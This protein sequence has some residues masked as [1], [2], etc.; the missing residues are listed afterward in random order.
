MTSSFLYVLASAFFL[1]LAYSEDFEI[2]FPFREYKKKI[3]ENKKS[4]RNFSIIL[5][6]LAILKLLFPIWPGMIVF[7]D[8]MPSFSLFLLSYLVSRN[9]LDLKSFRLLILI[10]LLLHLLFPSFILI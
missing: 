5:F 8:L 3:A 2:L 7:G 1:L 9:S 10:F 4:S 6:V